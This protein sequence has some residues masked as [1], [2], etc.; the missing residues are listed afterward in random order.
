MCTKKCNKCE[1]DKPFSDF[2]NGKD[3]NGLYYICKQCKTEQSQQRYR[4]KD[5]LTRWVDVTVADTQGRAKRRGIKFTLTKEFLRSLY[6][7]QYG[8]CVYCT[9]E[10]DLNGTQHDHRRSPSIDRLIP[11]HGYVEDNVV[12]SC[13]RCNAIKND[14]TL[15]EL[16]L[17][18]ESL[19]TLLAKLPQQVN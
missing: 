15:E 1:Q 14:A 19:A 11:E 12:L 17:L 13:H 4:Q 8:N 16:Q 6:A 18:T 10:F 2:P 5:P 9:K 3:A 7:H